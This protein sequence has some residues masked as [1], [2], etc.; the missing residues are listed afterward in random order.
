MFCE[1]YLAG[2]LGEGANAQTRDWGEPTKG[3]GCRPEYHSE[4]CHLGLSRL[5][6][7]IFA[8]TFFFPG[9]SLLTRKKKTGERALQENSH[10]SPP[11][12]AEE[13]GA[14]PSG[15]LPLT[16]RH[17]PL[18]LESN[19]GGTTPALRPFGK[20]RSPWKAALPKVY[21]LKIGRLPLLQHKERLGSRPSSWGLREGETGV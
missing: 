21:D 13:G 5:P 18:G 2:E 1:V 15:G 4:T 16:R 9:P 10:L 14:A 6:H 7:C 3:S 11:L 8:L 17:R 20:Q 19:G 12:S